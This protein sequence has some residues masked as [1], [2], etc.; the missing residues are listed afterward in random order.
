ME[1]ALHVDLGNEQVGCFQARGF[2]RLGRITTEAELAWLRDVYDMMI[3]KK[4]G[5]TPDE[6]A[7]ATNGSGPL[8]LIT[9]IAPEGI[10]PALQ[11][12]LLWHNARIILARLLGV[13]QIHLLSG[14]RAFFKPAGGSETP[15]HQDA[16]YHALPYDGASVWLTLD[17]A[18]HES[19]CMQYIEKSHLGAALPHHT[20]GGCLIADGVDSASAMA[21]PAVPGEA[22]AHH[23]RTL[24]KAGPNTTTR[25]RRALVVVCRVRRDT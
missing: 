7:H 1:D 19:G 6:L 14:W 20:H 9:L 24:H 3:K 8:S 23:C 10:V 2:L 21:C 13:E 4:T 15:W 17:P 16:A 12:T 22:I 11:H 5:Y 25:P 18:T